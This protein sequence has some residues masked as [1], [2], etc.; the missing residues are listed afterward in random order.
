MTEK[1][2]KGLEKR[3]KENEEFIA[4]VEKRCIEDGDN[5]KYR[6]T[7]HD[8]IVEMEVLGES[9]VF[10]R[11]KHRYKSKM[12]TTNDLIPWHKACAQYNETG[13]FCLNC[14]EVDIDNYGTNYIEISWDEEGKEREFWS[15][16]SLYIEGHSFQMIEAE[17]VFCEAIPTYD[18]YYDT[19]IDEESWNKLKEKLCSLG[20][21]YRQLLDE[22]SVWV[23]DG[24]KDHK[25]FTM[26][27]N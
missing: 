10:E 26:S 8:G 20:G 24:F 18:F 5:L 6:I 4:R 7:E 2:R 25:T 19:V 17:H 12:P 16:D 3:R 14:H 27:G 23:R 1:I 22:M 21:E 13:K 11:I 15:D 9:R